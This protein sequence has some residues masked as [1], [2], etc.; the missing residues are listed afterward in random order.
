MVLIP[1]IQDKLKEKLSPELFSVV[2]WFIEN[3]NQSNLTPLKLQK[4]VFFSQA[5]N[6]AYT[7]EPLFEEDF[8]AR[9]GGPVIDSIYKIFKS[10]WYDKDSV[11]KIDHVTSSLDNATIDI[12][13]EIKERYWHLSWR[14]LSI[15]THENWSP[16]KI[17]RDSNSLKEWQIS[18]VIINKD[19]IDDIFTKWMSDE[20]DEE[21]EVEVEVL[22]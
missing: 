12:L 16:R 7:W 4:L 5:W 21:L 13:L 3:N 8:E 10:Q 9:S 6:L 2:N 20:L 19:I 18:N 15:L 22:W 11:I 14:E 17:V 1:N